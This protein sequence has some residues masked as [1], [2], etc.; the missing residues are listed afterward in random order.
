TILFKKNEDINTFY[1]ECYDYY[2]LMVEK[3]YLCD[4]IIYPTCIYFNICYRLYKYYLRIYLERF[5]KLDLMF[6]KEKVN[7][8]ILNYITKLSLVGSFC[9]FCKRNY[10]ETCHLQL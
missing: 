1:H 4:E 5:D 6:Q 9:W 10:G 7:K 3:K 2:H 8:A